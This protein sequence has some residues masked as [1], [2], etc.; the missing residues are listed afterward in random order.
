MAKGNSGGLGMTMAHGRHEDWRSGVTHYTAVSEECDRGGDD[1]GDVVVVSIGVGWKCSLGTGLKSNVKEN[2]R[3]SGPS[4]DDQAGERVLGL[5]KA[6][7]VRA[8]CGDDC[9]IAL[10]T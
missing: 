2:E 5:V 7:R 4:K 1:D 6:S 8:F 9:G 3:Q 10:V